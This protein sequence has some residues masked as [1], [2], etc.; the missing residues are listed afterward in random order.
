MTRNLK[1]LNKEQLELVHGGATA[2][3][4]YMSQTLPLVT[5]LL[6]EARNNPAFL[7][8]DAAL[9]QRDSVKP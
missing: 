2:I 9:L 5:V 4:Y 6:L 7:N 8:I 3:E 1:E